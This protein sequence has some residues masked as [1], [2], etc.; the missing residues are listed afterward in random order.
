MDLLLDQIYD[1]TYVRTFSTKNGK[2]MFEVSH[3]GELYNVIPRKYQ[4]DNPPEIFRC[5]VKEITDSGYVKLTQDIEFILRDYYKPEEYYTFTIVKE[6]PN[7]RSGLPTY[8]VYN[9]E[10]ELEHRYFSFDEREFAP[11]DRIRLQTRVKED[12]Y[13]VP[14]LF[15]YLKDTEFEPYSPENVFADIPHSDLYEVYFRDFVPITNDLAVIQNEMLEKIESENRLWIFDYLKLLKHWATVRT[16]ENLKTAIDCNLLIIDIEEWLLKSGLLTKFSSANRDETRLKAETTI[17]NSQIDLEVLYSIQEGK[18]IEYMNDLL[19]EIKIASGVEHETLYKKLLR[20]VIIDPD[21][22]DT[23]LH[24]IAEIIA[25]SS[26]DANDVDTLKIITQV[27][28]RKVIAIKK[29]INSRIHYQRTPE[30]NR[31]QLADIT[32]GLGTLLMIYEKTKEEQEGLDVKGTFAELCKY[33]AFLTDREHATLLIGKAL[34]VTMGICDTLILDTTKLLSVAE[35]PAPLIQDIL[36][37]PVMHTDVLNASLSGHSQIQYRDRHLTIM[38]TASHVKVVKTPYQVFT[39]PGTA[40]NL[41]SGEPSAQAWDEKST[42]PYYKERWEELAN[43]ELDSVT[44]GEGEVVTVRV[45]E[46]NNL[47]NMVFCTIEGTDNRID[48]AITQFEYLPSI[49]VED[50]ND[51]FESGMRFR[52]IYHEQRG[53]VYFSLKSE[54]RELSKAVSIKYGTSNHDGVC[55]GIERGRWAF[56]ITVTGAICV[57]RIAGSKN[58]IVVGKA[59]SL[60]IRSDE[61]LYGFPSAIVLDV[62]QINQDS[63]SLLKNQLRMLCLDGPG[64][65]DYSERYRQMPHI[66]LIVDQ[67]LR[68]VDD[69]T[70]RYNLYQAMRVIARAENS[71]LYEYYSSKIKYLEA[72]SE[73]AS[74]VSISDKRVDSE[75]VVSVFPSL[76]EQKSILYILSAL[77]NIDEVDFLLNTIN[78]QERNTNISKIAGLVLASNIIQSYGGPSE[79]LSGIRGFIAEELGASPVSEASDDQMYDYNEEKQED[80]LLPVETYYGIEDQTQE[81]KTSIVYTPESSSPD[82]ESQLTVI[83]RTICGFLNS[84]GGT[85]WIGVQD[86]GY[87]SGISAD[88]SKLDCN[89]DKYERIIRQEIVQCFGKDINGTIN[90]DFRDDRG[91]IV[92]RVVIPPYFRPVSIHNDFYQR[93]G[94]E[95]RILKGN[96]LVLFIERRMMEKRSSIRDSEMVYTVIPE[97][98]EPNSLTQNTSKLEDSGPN[99]VE[100]E[101]GDNNSE[102]SDT[103]VNTEISGTGI[104]DDTDP[105]L[106]DTPEERLISWISKGRQD[107]LRK[108]LEHCGGSDIPAARNAIFSVF[109]NNLVPEEDFWE[110][111]TIILESN[112]RLFRKPLADSVLGYT[113]VSSLDCSDEVIDHVVELLLEEEEKIQQGLDFLIPF[114]SLLTK[115]SRQLLEEKAGFITMPEGFETLFTILEADYSKKIEILSSLSDNLAAYY[116]MFQAISRDEEE[117]GIWHV[118]KIANLEDILSE[119]KKSYGGSIIWGLIHKTAFHDEEVMKDKEAEDLLSGGY[120]KILELVN[121][122]TAKERLKQRKKEIYSYVGETLTFRV[123]ASYKNHYLLTTDVYRALLPKQF[124]KDRYREGDVINALVRKAYRQERLFL[125]TQNPA[126]TAELESINMVETGDVVDVRFSLNQGMPVPDIQGMSP[127]TGRV[128][129][130]PRHF[131]YKKKYQAEVIRAYFTSCELALMGPINTKD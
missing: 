109:L 103:D 128:I 66:L 62:A 83:M 56:F 54:I 4:V 27:F 91:K 114:R 33:L 21:I 100:T 31:E 20:L 106:N 123:I 107:Q 127:L 69:N 105:L 96:D 53:K 119:M 129:D 10:T 57:A 22:I 23:Q 37:V 1:F 41:A 76:E 104:I 49:F 55:L 15:F 52:V 88:L 97:I 92:C 8:I 79:V 64:E 58:R 71:Q 60:R 18:Q 29:Q 93:Q 50:L 14:R 90:I 98:A 82:Q 61:E 28:R 44:H 34:D 47:K 13:G 70:V 89:T 87:A 17:L 124:A 85:L 36:N 46:A 120:M 111:V 5:R 101:Q 45:K 67:Y 19:R 39:I 130:Y 78:G 38:P 2:L 102:E 86:S 63:I 121:K 30:I 24:A 81:F 131:D 40:I 65:S 84:K 51:V 43:W 72:L 3:E 118:R 26:H 11:G 113:N 74:G 99:N 16:K 68:F 6:L 12:K 80:L 25:R 126:K 42:I 116:A 48:G 122:N 7:D 115:E 108:W 9:E 112:S 77:G 59:Y 95:T 32:V 35:D 117:N 75:S 94:N 110:L 73:F 125:V